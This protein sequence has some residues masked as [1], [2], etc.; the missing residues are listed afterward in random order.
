MTQ[1]AIISP[2]DAL[3]ISTSSASFGHLVDQGRATACE[4]LFLPE[5][6]LIFGPGSPKPGELVGLEA[7]RR[8]LEARQAQTHV[9]TRHLATNFRFELDG[10]E[11]VRLQSILTVFRSDDEGRAPTVSVVADVHEVFAR[12]A[13]GEWRILERLTVPVF[14]RT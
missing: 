13:G 4:H 9:I 2:T 6:K 8:F 14:A 12:D 5:A 10:P 11:R 7:I 3:A 1:A